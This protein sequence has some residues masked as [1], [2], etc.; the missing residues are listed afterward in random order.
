[1]T[2]TNNASPRKMQQPPLASS[3]AGAAQTHADGLVTAYWRQ[4]SDA[5]NFVVTPIYLSPA[6]AGQAIARAPWEYSRDGTT[7]AAWP[8]SPS[9]LNNTAQPVGGRGRLLGASFPAD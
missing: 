7:W 2:T 6:D 3:A 5:V 1:M 4:S 9:I 8:T